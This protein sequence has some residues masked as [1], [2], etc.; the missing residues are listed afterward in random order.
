ME[1]EDGVHG[2]PDLLPAPEGEGEVAESAANLATGT[3]LLDH[4]G[5]T[6]ELHAVVVVLSHAFFDEK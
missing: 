4:G 6:D 2:L 3:S 1:E 5:R